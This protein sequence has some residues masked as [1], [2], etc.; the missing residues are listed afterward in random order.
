MPLVNISAGA[1]TSA[2]YLGRKGPGGGGFPTTPYQYYTGWNQ[3]GFKSTI[4][5]QVQ[6]YLGGTPGTTYII[7]IYGWNA[8]TQ[9]WTTHN[10]TDDMTSESGYW[11]YFNVNHV[12][13]AGAD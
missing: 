4:D 2:T 1:D 3:V 13:N 10:A 5:K 6:T 12:I 9:V 7:P 11:V 8:T